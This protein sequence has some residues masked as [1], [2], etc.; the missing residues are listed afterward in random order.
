MKFQIE[1]VT[2]H[3]PYDY[4]YPEKYSY[5]VELKRAL[6]AN[7][8]ALLEM[9]PGTGKT[10]LLIYISH[11]LIYFYIFFIF[12]YAPSTVLRRIYS[13]CHDLISRPTK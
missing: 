6:D 11:F 9:P 8:H 5:M 3:F 10:I 12:F 7:G 2:V 4:I 1:D 13:I